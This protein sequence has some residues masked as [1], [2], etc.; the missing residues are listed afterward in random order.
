MSIPVP[1]LC[2]FV[3]VPVPVTVPVSIPV[4]GLSPRLKHISQIT[5]TIIHTLILQPVILHYITC[6]VSLN[7]IS[8]YSIL[9][10][11][12]VLKDLGTYHVLQMFV[13]KSTPSNR[14]LV[15]SAKWSGNCDWGVNEEGP[16]YKTLILVRAS[17]S[18]SVKALVNAKNY[19]RTYFSLV[20][21][22]FSVLRTY[23]FLNCRCMAASFKLQ[24]DI[25]SSPSTVSLG[26]CWI[27]IFSV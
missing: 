27:V 9:T 2:V 26:W 12:T 18:W 3:P 16:C 10:S 1:S 15:D 23:F 4:S 19:F 20:R 7:Y 22:Y 14:F 6:C 25:R 5:V 13:V 21:T 8:T 17:F 11:N 24:D